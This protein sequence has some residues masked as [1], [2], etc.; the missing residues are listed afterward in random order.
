MKTSATKTRRRAVDLEGSNPEE[1]LKRLA[2]IAFE[3]N[4]EM[5]DAKNR[6]DKARKELYSKMKSLGIKSVDAVANATDGTPVSIV[7]K[8]AV[9]TR[10][11]IDV[12]K[13]KKLVSNKLFMEMASVTQAAVAKFA[14]TSILNQIVE[15]K[16]GEEYVSIKPKK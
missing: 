10:N 5:N 2:T 12:E 7:A 15:P 9:L 13:L 1:E 6:G 11:V 4:R 14:G 16:D 8:L 3:A